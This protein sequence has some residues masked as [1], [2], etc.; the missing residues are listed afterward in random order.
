MK[1]LN[2]DKNPIYKM[3]TFPLVSSSFRDPSGI[4]FFVNGEVYRQVN[5][6]YKKDYEKLMDSGLY[7]L[8]IKKN[9]S[10]HMK[11]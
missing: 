6:S 1:N 11:K 5:Q 8:L 10:Y 9:F 4:L 7:D 3:E 2:Q